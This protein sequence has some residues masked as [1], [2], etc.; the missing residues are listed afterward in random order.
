MRNGLPIPSRSNAD[1]RPL[2]RRAA[3]LMVAAALAA[4]LL[5]APSVQAEGS[6]KL[7]GLNY[8]FRDLTGNDAQKVRQSG[9][10]TLR[11]MF[12][13]PRIEGKQGVFDWSAPDKLVGDL[14]AKG[15]RVIPTLWGS[16]KWVANTAVTAPIG[17][18]KARD[19]WR[20]FL[21]AVVGR[22]GPGGDYWTN[23]YPVEHPGKPAL[24]IGTWQVWNEPNLRSAMAPVDPGNY[25]KLLELSASAI[26]AA[27]SSAKVM[28]AGMPGYAGNANA[29]D[30]LN[31]VYQTKGVRNAFDVAALHPYARNVPQMLGEIRRVRATMQQHGDGHKPL[32]ITEIGWGSLPK[33]ATAYGQTK[34][35][36]GQARILKRALGA[37]KNNRRRWR[38]QRV[39]WFNFRDPAGGSVKTCSFCSSAGLLK[40][41]GTPKP[42]WSAFRSFTR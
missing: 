18:P 35:L 32:W 6:S 27:D 31:R 12:V 36:K 3:A 39:L 28:F 4:G 10:K 2:V 8:S 1:G 33:D 41:D 15:I 37:L 29:W 9:A 17:S 34:G 22:Y 25:A 21:T 19:A 23:K 24:P 13:W 16:P 7:F 40:H 30:F 14:A 42:A 20:Q 5:A 26:R 11:W 38:I